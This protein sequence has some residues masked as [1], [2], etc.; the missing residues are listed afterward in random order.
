MSLL[1]AGVAEGGDEKCLLTDR[2]LRWWCMKLTNAPWVTAQ[3]YRLKAQ[4]ASQWRR[5]TQIPTKA[6]RSRLLVLP[7][8]FSCRMNNWRTVLWQWPKRHLKV[9]LL[10]LSISLI[11]CWLLVMTQLVTLTCGCSRV[12]VLCLVLRFRVDLVGCR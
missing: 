6:L 4:L 12:L 11:S 9:A 10:F 1:G 8:L 5:P 3:I 2:L 7:I